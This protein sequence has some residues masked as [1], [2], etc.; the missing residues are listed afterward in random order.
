MLRPAK[1]LVFALSALLLAPVGYAQIITLG[2]GLG[3]ECYQAVNNPYARATRAE[4]L[5]TRA[6]MDDIMNASTKAATYVNRGI[7]RMRQ[8]KAQEALSDFLRAKEIRPDLPDLYINEGAVLVYLE[9]YEDAL[10]A[11]Q[12]AVEIES[13]N[14]HVAYLNLGLAREGLGDL[15]GAY[16]DIARALELAPD[17][18][19]AERELNRFR[20]HSEDGLTNR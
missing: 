6:L 1:A 2:S 18:P 8:D 13:D 5:C 3:A 19:V 20:I 12:K 10:S 16:F 17:W 9:R 11:L 4:K 14:L 15:E 7:S